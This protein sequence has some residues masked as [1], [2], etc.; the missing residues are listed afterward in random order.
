MSSISFFFD[1]FKVCRKVW[2]FSCH[3]QEVTRTK[4]KKE[5]FDRQC[6]AQK[7]ADVCKIFLPG[8]EL[9]LEWKP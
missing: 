7:T 6:S 5:M 8:V 2:N 3:L 4:H 9:K 1:N